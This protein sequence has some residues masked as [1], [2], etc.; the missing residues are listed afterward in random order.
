MHCQP[1]KILSVDFF[2][3]SL[4]MNLCAKRLRMIFVISQPK[5]TKTNDYA[6]K[7]E[8]RDTIQDT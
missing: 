7:Q 8:R 4:Q 5:T 2:V 6:R 3:V 1:T